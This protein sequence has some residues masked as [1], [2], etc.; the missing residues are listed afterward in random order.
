MTVYFVVVLLTIIFSCLALPYEATTGESILT[1]RTLNTKIFLFL[2]VTCLVL[3]AGLRYWVGTD[4]GSYYAA[5]ER[6]PSR[7]WEYIKEVDEPGFP[8]IAS[9]INLF[10]KDGA[11][12]IFVTA[13]FTIASILYI[14]YKYTDTYVFS[15]L[16][17]VFVGIWH[18]S[19]NGVR[20][21]FA[22]A[23][24]L[25]GHRF[26]LDKKPWKYLLCVLLAFLFHASAIV[27]IIPYFILRNKI[28][29]KN[30]LILIIGSIILLY[31]YEFI[32]TLIGALKDETIDTTLE[33]MS[34]QVNILRVIICVV[35]AAFCLFLYSKSEKDAEQTFYLNTLILYGLLSVIGMNSPYLS[36]VNIYLL[37]FLPMAMGKLVVFEDKK[38]EILAKWVIIILFFVFW[39]IE[40]GKDGTFRFI[41]QR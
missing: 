4:Y 20:Q 40:I 8:I 31:N 5:L 12:F 27:M 37:V 26:I 13:A 6:Y 34:N 38:L 22:A 9:I 16:L 10:T 29:V 19:F 1:K 36:R 18:G 39:Y 23:I 33:Y 30:I 21:F 35:P 41:W 2:V 28:S 11:V 14:T 24:I 7:L 3:V 32:F 17:F 15:S 25:L